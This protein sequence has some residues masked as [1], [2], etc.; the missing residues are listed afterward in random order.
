VPQQ[1]LEEQQVNTLN[2]AIRNAPGV[3]QANAN[4]QPAFTGATIRGFLA[5]EGRN[6]S[7]N[8]LSYPGSD[9]TVIFSNIERIEVLGGPASVLFGSGNPGGTI[10]IVTEQPLPD[11]TYSVEVSAGSYGFYRGAIDLTGPL[12]DARTILY[13][14]NASYESEE[15]F[16]DFTQRDIPAVAGVLSFE[17]GENTDLTFD[18]EYSK[19][20]QGYSNGLPARGTVLPNPNG[21]IPRDRNIG[22]EDSSYSPEV[23]RVG[24]NLEHRFS[25]NWSLQNAFYFTDLQ[26]R[27]RNAYFALSLDPDLRTLERG[28]NNFDVQSQSF[29]LF[30]NIVGNF[31]TGSI[32]HRLLFGVDLRRVDDGNSFIG[33]FRGTP[34]DLFDPVYMFGEAGDH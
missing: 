20:N 9:G 8:G 10:N 19:I 4:Y 15:G 30:T 21:E 34:L 7:R 33:A 31:S 28:A 5:G 27:I 13:R 17:L 1:V 14:L 3:T 6:F 24:Y 16:V 11:P 12:N 29:D 22:D 2:E 23:L 32:D 26:Y 18:V 25:E